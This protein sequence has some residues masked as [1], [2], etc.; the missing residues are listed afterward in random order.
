MF[1]GGAD[2]LMGGGLDNSSAPGWLLIRDCDYADVNSLAMDTLIGTSI[3]SFRH[4][5]V[6][7]QG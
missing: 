4:C 2:V 3:W 5:K 1:D 7:D 6:I